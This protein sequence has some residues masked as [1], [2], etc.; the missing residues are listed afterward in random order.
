MNL[1]RLALLNV[2]R[3]SSRSLL[4]TVAMALAAFMM[5]AS[6][7]PASGHTPQ[8]ARGYRAFLGGDIIIYPPWVWPGESNLASIDGGQLRHAVVPRTFGSP[9][10]YFHPDYYSKGYVS[11][12]PSPGYA[13]FRTAAEMA[14]VVSILSAHPQVVKV[15]PYRCLPVL[16]GEVRLTYPDGTRRTASLEG[17]FVRSCPE[18]TLSALNSQLVLGSSGPLTSTG[19]RPAVLL[20]LYRILGRSDQEAMAFVEGLPGGQDITFLLPRIVPDTR[21]RE[22]GPRFDLTHPVAAEA[23]VTGCYWAPTRKWSWQIT[24]LEQGVPTTASMFEQLYLEAPEILVTPDVFDRL[25]ETAG[26][27]EDDLP[28]V[29]A[30]LVSVADFVR[31]EEIAEELR[32]VLDEFTV[33]SVVTDAHFA[34]ARGWPE[35]AYVCPPGDRPKRMPLGQPAVPADTRSTFG[36]LLFGIA[37]VVAAGSNTLTVLTRRTEFAVLRAVGLRAFE[38]AI[39]VTTEVVVISAVGIAAGYSAGEVLALPLLLANRP[40]DVPVVAYLTPY[41]LRDLGVIIPVAIGSAVV[42][43][44]FPVMRSLRITVLEALRTDG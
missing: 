14:E 15:S 34:N 28:P 25:L 6:L 13:M 30:L 10:L 42:S 39:V 12:R 33:V 16:G 37:A 31:C 35:K 11:D 40:A 17:F 26:L 19:D 24:T 2:I 7:T 29:G 23:T 38:V 9:L 3:N 22:V 36:Y 5:T 41:L 18:V 4:T 43:S 32:G 20:N 8:A 27:P 1:V 44:L 21:E